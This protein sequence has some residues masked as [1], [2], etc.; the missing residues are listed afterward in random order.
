MKR[1]VL[2][3]LLVPALAPASAMG[4]NA[5]GPPIFPAEARDTAALML[6]LVDGMTSVVRALRP[7]R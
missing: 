5:A 6:R 3:G 2:V 4:A 7:V 1:V